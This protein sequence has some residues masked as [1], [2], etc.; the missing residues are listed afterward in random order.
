M[1]IP[2]NP[3]KEENYRRVLSISHRGKKP[4]NFEL[5]KEGGK[6]T[7]FKKGMKK[8]PNAYKFPKGL[9]SKGMLGKKHKE[10]TKKK[11][12]NSNSISLKGKHCS[13][14]TE[15]K[16][17]HIPWC[18]GKTN[19]KLRE[20]WKN[21]QF[22]ER[23]I[24]KILKSLFKRPT[25]LEK[26]MIDMIE[27]YNLPYKYTGNGLFLIGGKNPD[28][29]NVNGEKICIEV[30]NRNVCKYWTKITPE[31]YKRRRIEHFAKW[32]WECIVLWEDDLENNALK[33]LGESY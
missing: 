7:R 15:F 26:Q 1:P 13:P 5:F 8:S 28:F 21:Q 22:R 19:P 2:K 30:R 12:G 20:L 16:K 4:K 14:K 18:K 6:K 29:V 17:G 10:E 32:G 11:I 3:K 33:V 9:I 25:S 24:K 23:R 31:E 27:K